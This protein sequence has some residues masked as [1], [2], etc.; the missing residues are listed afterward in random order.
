MRLFFLLFFFFKQK[1]AYAVRISDWSSDVCSS[2][3]QNVFA[4]E[5]AAPLLDPY[6]APLD[7]AADG[8]AQRVAVDPEP[9]RQFGLGRQ[10]R[11]LAPLSGPDLVRQRLLDLPPNRDAG[12]PVDH[13]HCISEER[14]VGKECTS[15]CSSRWLPS[16]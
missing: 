10:P 3:L 2:D 4:H 12:I 13:R 7:E 15:T 16:Y 5:D 6:Q 8:A 11:D 14:R 1:T 9:R